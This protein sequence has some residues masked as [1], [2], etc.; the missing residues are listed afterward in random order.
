MTWDPVLKRH[1]GIEIPKELGAADWG[2]MFLT[3]DQLEY[4]QN[5]VRHLHALRDALQAKL[6][7]PG[8]E[9]G[10]GAEGVD[11]ARVA[12]L[13]MSLIP[14]VV[15][16]RLRGIKVDRAR[17]EQTLT[18]YRDRAKLLATELRDELGAPGLN[19]A[20]QV[21]L[22]KVLQAD[23][24]EIQDTSKETLSA[25][26]HPVAG[27]ILECRR[28]AGLCTTMGGWLKNLDRDNR[29]FPPLNP[30]GADTGRFSCKDPNLLGVSR[31]PE[32]RGVFIA[33]MVTS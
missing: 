24:L 31:E 27:R 4:C 25:S 2:G 11:L 26:V 1:L 8:D 14:L 15:D 7:N 21:Q 30:L 3:D 29:L 9:H 16:I 17:L 6:A 28:L 32:I 18:T 22:L 23:G 19:F 33:E 10:D 12:A 13:E 20:S 5:D